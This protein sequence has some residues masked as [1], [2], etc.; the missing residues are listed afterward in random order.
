M[1]IQVIHTF[2]YIGREYAKSVEESQGI[3]ALFHPVHLWLNM[4][5]GM[6]VTTSFDT[7]VSIIYGCYVLAWSMAFRIRKPWMSLAILSII[8]VASVTSM[9]LSPSY[10]MGA[11]LVWQYTMFGYNLRT[12][13]R[14]H[15]PQISS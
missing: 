12:A 5:L 10:S 8:M 6:I 15:E 7:P 11:Y 9:E 1:L 2:L 3:D 14:Y 13:M 4:L